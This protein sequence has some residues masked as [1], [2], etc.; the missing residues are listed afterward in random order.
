M[1][2]L[3]M[4]AGNTWSVQDSSTK[5]NLLFHSTCRHKIGKL[6]SNGSVT[7]A[8]VENPFVAP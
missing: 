8:Q 7:A 3:L 1:A 2:F 5:S 6:R 4:S